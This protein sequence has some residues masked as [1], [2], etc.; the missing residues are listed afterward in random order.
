MKW[1][2]TYIKY[3]SP[4][5]ENPEVNLRRASAFLSVFNPFNT[6]SAITI[7]Q[8]DQ[9]KSLKV[10]VNYIAAKKALFADKR[11]AKLSAPSLHALIH[12]LIYVKLDEEPLSA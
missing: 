8:P 9:K 2:N 7:Q 11:I 1:L 5:T 3:A 6:V 12:K 4:L 10:K